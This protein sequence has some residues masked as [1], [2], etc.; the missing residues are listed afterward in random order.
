MTKC[1]FEEEV[2]RRVSS[3]QAALLFRCSGRTWVAEET[4][5]R[6]ALAQTFKA[7]PTCVGFNVFFEVYCGF[8][9]NN[10]LT[11]VVFGAS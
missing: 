5:T 8:S 2:P 1:F 3:P 7:A 10:T 4:G 9:I 6:E 11:S